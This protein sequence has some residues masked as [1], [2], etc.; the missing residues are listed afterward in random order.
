MNGN[1][2][3]HTSGN[4]DEH[5]AATDEALVALRVELVLFTVRDGRLVVLMIKRTADP[6]RGFWSLPG[7]G[8][9]G[10]ETLDAAADRLVHDA[11]GLDCSRLHIEQLRSYVT[12]DDA[13]SPDA[14]TAARRS[15]SVAYM[16]LLP[17]GCDPAPGST[18]EAFRWWAVDDLA[19]DDPTIEG[20]ELAYDHARIV[21]DGVERCRSKLEYTTIATSF[22]R[23]PFTLGELR[24]IYENIWGVT[25]HHSNFARKLTSS[26]G[27]LIA[28]RDGSPGRASL[29]RRGDATYVMPPLIRP[30]VEDGGT[31]DV[32]SD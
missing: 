17:A 8:P 10:D 1:P 21:S 27:Y 2:P 22:L 16:A 7:G 14:T 25:L 11:T 32:N 28:E 9:R 13:P 23:E 19:V 18:A 30:T 12:L 5:S 15:A 4:S 24:R 31:G 3:S 26:P 29:Y 20:P 6:Y